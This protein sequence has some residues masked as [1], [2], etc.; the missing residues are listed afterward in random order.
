MAA[1]EDGVI[2]AGSVGGGFVFPEFVPAYDGMASLCKLLAAARAG[3]TAALGA[4]RRAARVR[5]RPPPGALPLGAQGRGHADP[6]RAARRAR[7]S[8]CTDGI[9]VYDER[10]WAQVL[11]DPDEPLVHIYAE[12]KTRGG[13]RL[14]RSRVPRPSSRRSSARETRPRSLASRNPQVEVDGLARRW[15]TGGAR[16]RP[17]LWRC[18]VEALPDLGDPLRPGA[19]RPDPRAPGR[20]ARDLVPTPAP[21][22]QDRHPACRAPVA[23]LHKQVEEG[24]EPAARDR[25]RQAGRDPRLEGARLRRTRSS[26]RPSGDLRPLP[27]V[28]LPEPRG[29]QLLLE[30]RRAPH[31]RRAG[32]RTRR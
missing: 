3:R 17:R 12:G 4:R 13:R 8:T 30:V 11:P 15:F 24:G 29:R 27:R 9:K 18:R 14:A 22:R 28:R 23:R 25:R 20:G 6:H 32:R 2:F 21:A 1:A 31:P 16:P 10:G 5:G 7:R 26:T 19:A